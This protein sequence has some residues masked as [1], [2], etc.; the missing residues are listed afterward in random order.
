MSYIGN[1][2]LPDGMFKTD[3][4]IEFCCSTSSWSSL[5]PEPIVLPRDKSFYLFPYGLKESG[6]PKCQS[7]VGTT[8]RLEWIQYDL[9]NNDKDITSQFVLRGSHPSAVLTDSENLHLKL[10]LC[11]YEPGKRVL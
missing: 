1:G 5:D 10:Y 7:V 11:Y 6:L 8:S 4:K 9:E 3:T 2:T